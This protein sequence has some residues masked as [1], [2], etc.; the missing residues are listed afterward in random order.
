MRSH[1]LLVAFVLALWTNTSSPPAAF[2]QDDIE[3]AKA[4]FSRGTRLYQVG[5]YRQASEE[6]KAAHLAKPD[7]AFL[8]N[9]AQCHR[10]LGELE[11]AV[12]LYRRYLAGSPNA[13]NRAEVEDRIADLE[14]QVAAHKRGVS[15]SPLPGRVPPVSV[16]PIADAAVANPQPAGSSLRYLR[17]VAAG[18]TL[19]L[20]GGAIASGLSASS[21]FDDLKGTCGR[22]ADGCLE[23]DID[24]VKSRALLA[25]ILWGVAGV[26]AIG[27]GV[28]FYLTPRESVAQVAWRF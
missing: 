8:Y 21:T 13:S 1:R 28:M 7:P 15:A 26:A 4:H 19:A 25:N 12:T 11:Q 23:S 3:A 22:T 6:F 10:Q 18:V 2:A 17:W 9:I 16:Q 20:A 14:A 5:E 27:T 24:A